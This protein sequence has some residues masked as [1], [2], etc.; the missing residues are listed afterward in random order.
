MICITDELDFE[1][2]SSDQVQH[3]VPKRPLGEFSWDTPHRPLPFFENDLCIFQDTVKG[4]YQR[5]TL[6]RCAR[7]TRHTPTDAQI[8]AFTRYCVFRRT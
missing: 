1:N 3:L 4:F 6:L 2:L 7:N 5:L 8:E